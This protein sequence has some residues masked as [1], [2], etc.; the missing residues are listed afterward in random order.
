MKKELTN[1]LPRLM[2]DVDYTTAQIAA[3]LGPAD[4]ASAICKTLAKL[5]E[6][7][8][9]LAARGE[10]QPGKGWMTGKTVRPWLW[11]QID[12]AALATILM[13]PADNA[14]SLVDRVVELERRVKTLEER[15]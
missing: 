15:Q 5:A 13:P 10:P 9:S 4:D 12:A 6:R 3:M 14:T 8:P 2:P 11:R 1:L 7:H